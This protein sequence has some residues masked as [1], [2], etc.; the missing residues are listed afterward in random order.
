MEE[1]WKKTT[2]LFQI[3]WL[4]NLNLA[5]VFKL[6]IKFIKKIIINKFIFNN[7]IL[8]V[9]GNQSESSNFK[10][11]YPTVTYGSSQVRKS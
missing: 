7:C 9:T 11:L 5:I 2:K 4:I 10:I 1:K 8:P 6:L 3:N